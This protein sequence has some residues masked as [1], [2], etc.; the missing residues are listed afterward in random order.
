MASQ[1]ERKTIAREVEARAARVKT[2]AEALPQNPE[3]TALNAA[4]A[5]LLVSVEKLKLAV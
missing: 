1:D 5:E 4:I 3:T 2:T